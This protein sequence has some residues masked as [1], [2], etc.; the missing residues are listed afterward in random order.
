MKPHL[1]RNRRVLITGANGFLGS[2]L[3]R[4]L[5]KTQAQLWVLLRLRSER[6][7]LADIA[8]QLKVVE[9]DLL[10]RGSLHS[11][12]KQ[13]SPDI[14]YHLAASSLGA[15]DDQEGIDFAVNSLGAFHM[16]DLCAAQGVSRYIFSGTGIEYGPGDHL[17]ENHV[18]NP[19]S[20][21]GASK[22]AGHLISQAIGR[23]KNLPTVSLRPFTI[24]GPWDR[25]YH[26]VPS[27]IISAL[28]GR[29][30]QATKGDQE[31]DLV[32]IDDVIRGF[33]LA[34]QK[35]EAVG[36]TIN[37]CTGRGV[38][39]RSLIEKILDLMG[40][41][42]QAVFGARPYRQEEIFKQTGSHA[43]ASRL[44]GWRPAISLSE[45]LRRTIDWYHANQTILSHLGERS[46][47]P[48]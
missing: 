16:A 20:V 9:A 32:Y 40:H 18:L 37:L 35:T 34:A 48:R 28:Q 17:S 43:K 10:D 1:W 8:P 22:A 11:A 33:V 47:W 25:T 3:A 2:H 45:G 26:L 6:I 19:S 4:A 21:Y 12:L 24:Y 27:V 38:T 23:N 29:E 41:P 5:L 46:L 31:R 42:V 39:I 14:V 30:I 36:Q 15:E 44:L 7:R 13:A